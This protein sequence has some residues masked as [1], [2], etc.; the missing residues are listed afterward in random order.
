MSEISFTPD[1][2]LY[3]NRDSLSE[4]YTPSTIVGR[5]NEISQYHA[6]LQP[7]INGER[8]N[9][10]FLYG[11]TGVGKT[12]VTSYLLGQLQD[13]SEK[14]DVDL[15]VISLNCEGLNSSYQVAVNLV[16]KIRTPEHHIS[17]TGHPQYEVYEFLWNELDDLGGTVLIVLDEVDNIGE[18][19]SILYQI[20]RAR[21]NGN[22]NDAKVG[23]I[24]ISND[25]AFRENLSPKVR[26]S[27]CEKSISFPPYDATELE[28]VLE[29][30]AEVAFHEGALGDGVI[31]LC[32][33][34]G[35][36]DA[37][38][39]RKA[40]DLLRGAG[41]IARAENADTV[42]TTHVKNAR[43]ELEREELMDG[44]ADL[45][46]HQQLVL[47]ALTTLEAESETPARSQTV[48][49]RYQELAEVAALDSRTS[50]R[51]RDFLADLSTLSIV[52]SSQRNDGLS[53][54][55]YREHKLKHDV[56]TVLSAMSDLIE[57]VGIH[58][59]VRQTIADSDRVMISTTFDS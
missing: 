43:D 9:N 47:Y 32:A 18:S 39:A 59:S 34:Y 6:A 58:Q 56:E 50:R 40:L 13:D 11:K 1:D 23:I 22:I 3:R 26:S 8:P 14:F 12:A 55:Q 52:V 35:A 37:G 28:A 36:Q 5:D 16:N 51:V 57:R 44:I 42:T 4:D 31:Q 54:G 46:D 7:V 27:L 2:S 49:Q 19:D 15:T 38:D 24:G 17:K 41:D 20:P 29:Q 33:A 48:Y 25:L 53:G 45:A 21:S 10:I 30:R